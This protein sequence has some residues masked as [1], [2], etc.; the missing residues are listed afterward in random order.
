MILKKKNKS[1]VWQQLQ[2][3]EKQR[4][5]RFYQ[6]FDKHNTAKDYLYYQ[7]L[8]ES[9]LMKITDDFYSKTYGFNDIVYSNAPKEKQD[10]IWGSYVDGLNL[11]TEEDAIQLSLITRRVSKEQY[12]KETNYPLKNDNYE[13]YREEFNELTNNAYKNG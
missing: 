8:F 11:L 5:N 4:L 13:V 12:K 7:E 9:G 6:S 3:P 1:S 10:S 2:K